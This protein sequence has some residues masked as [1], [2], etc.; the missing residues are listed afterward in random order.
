[1]PA[2][3]VAHNAVDSID[4]DDKDENSE[5]NHNEHT[6]IPEDSGQ[7]RD[8]VA[9]WILGLSNNYGYVVMLSAAHDI[10]EAFGRQ[11]Y[12]SPT[13]SEHGFEHGAFCMG[14]NCSI[15]STGVLLLANTLPSMAI[16]LI[17]P[18]LPFYIL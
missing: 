1:M 9:F 12:D 18:F 2:D 16:T 15:M 5:Y 3:V 14:R 13:I 7:W 10:I 6:Q 11:N 8:L 4:D 17:A